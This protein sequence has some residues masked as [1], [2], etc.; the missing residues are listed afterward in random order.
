MSQSDILFNLVLATP[1]STLIQSCIAPC[2]S[3]R[4]YQLRKPMF[5]VNSGCIKVL[6]SGIINSGILETADGFASDKDS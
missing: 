6:F 2:S 4:R 1:M 5:I 3:L